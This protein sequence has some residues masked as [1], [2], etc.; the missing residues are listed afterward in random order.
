MIPRQP[1]RRQGWL[2][3]EE[4][5]QQIE[6]DLRPLARMYWAIVGSAGVFGFVLSLLVFIYTGDRDQIKGM[7]SVL[8]EQGTAIKVML[9]KL[10]NL[11]EHHNK[12]EA[13]VNRSAGP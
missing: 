7:Q 2:D 11:T 5:L 12:L 10:E 4:R 6:Q 13:Q 3:N 9:N 1:E 8:Y